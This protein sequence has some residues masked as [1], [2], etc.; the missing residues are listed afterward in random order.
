MHVLRVVGIRNRQSPKTQTGPSDDVFQK[1]KEAAA[2]A[3]R[4]AEQAKKDL[5]KNET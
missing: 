4:S 3:T 1:Q 2:L 5:E